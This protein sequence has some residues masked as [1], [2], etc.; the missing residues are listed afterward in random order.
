[1]SIRD[2]WHKKPACGRVL[3]AFAITYKIGKVSDLHEYM[4]FN[5]LLQ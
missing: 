1:M 4:P 3:F 5:L 2:K